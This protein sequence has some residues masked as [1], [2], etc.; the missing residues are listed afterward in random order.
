MDAYTR[1]KELMG[2]NRRILQLTHFLQSLV[3][4]IFYFVNFNQQ[5]LLLPERSC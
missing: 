1:D 5:M 2:L 4:E 3:M